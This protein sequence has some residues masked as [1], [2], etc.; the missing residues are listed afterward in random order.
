MPARFWALAAICSILPDADTLG[1]WLGVPYDSTFGHRG[2]THSFLFAAI[3]GLL[4]VELFFSDA[5]RFSREW[6]TLALFFFLATASHTLLDMTTNGGLGVALFSPFSNERYFLPWRPV[7]VS[8]IGVA[9]FFSA[10]GIAVIVSEMLWIWLLATVMVAVEMW[11]R[12]V[13]R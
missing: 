9:S 12:M 3:I 2:F 5:P 11:R 4:V 6:W 13:G 1:F 8:P 7:K 10:R